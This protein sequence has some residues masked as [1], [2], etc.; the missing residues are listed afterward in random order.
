[1]DIG[2]CVASQISDIDYVV[3]AEK[4]GFTDAWFADSQM[5]WSDCYA[6]L[7]LAAD[8]TS[9]INIGTGVAVAGTRLPSVHAAG[10]ASINQLAPRRTFF[11]VGSGNTAMRIMGLPP[12]RIKHFEE[13]LIEIKPLLSGKESMMKKGEKFIPIIHI[14][15]DKKF[16]NFIEKIPMYISGFGPKSLGLAGKYGDGA[17]LAFPSNAKNMEYCWLMIEEGAKSIGRQ[18][19]RDKYLTTALTAVSI[20]DEGEK[21]NSERVLKE[22]G[23]MAMA[24]IHYTY[25]QWRNFNHPPP[26]FFEDIWDDYCSMLEEFPKEKLHQRIHA[27]HNC[28][29][30]PEEQR[31]LTPS[32]L[33]STCLIG[34]KEKLLEKITELSAA[35]LDKLMI[36]PGLKPRY[37]VLARVSKDLIQT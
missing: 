4:L 15:Q 23:P 7:A 10:I 16:V 37:E 17:I 29:V 31:F 36:L 34:T 2:V 13:F 19:Q 8:K 24:S 11:G 33:E 26:A 5:L 28:W 14:M 1:M 3:E 6:S 22:C 18:I 21:I 12:Q 20:L 25:D 30:I 32:I 35:G 9:Q 27:G